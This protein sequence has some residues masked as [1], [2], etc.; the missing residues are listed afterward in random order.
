MKSSAATIPHDLSPERM[1]AAENAAAERLRQDPT[2]RVAAI[3]VLLE[4]GYSANQAWKTVAR[5]LESQGKP[6]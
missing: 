3:A 4:A 5:L 6:S 1:R 2:T